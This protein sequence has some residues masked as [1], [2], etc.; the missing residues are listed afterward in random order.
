MY[1]SPSW[2]QELWVARETLWAGFLTSVQCSALAIVLGTLIGVVAGLALTYGRVW[3]RAPFR[4]YVDLI[5]GTPVF[6]LVLACFYM[7]P[8]LGWQ[9]GAFEAGV[10]GWGEPAQCDAVG[11]VPRVLAQQRA[12][13][14]LLEVLDH[15]VR[16]EAVLLQHSR[17]CH[18]GQ[19]RHPLARVQHG[20]RLVDELQGARVGLLGVVEDPR[21]RALLDHAA[22]AHDDDARPAAEGEVAAGAADVGGIAP[23]FPALRLAGRIQPGIAQR[24]A[25]AVVGRGV[26]L[27]RRGRIPPAAR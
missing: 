4:F 11:H 10:L 26:V 27:P 12:I 14:V 24:D 6:V 22:L 13:D 9:I 2:L 8:A 19:V 15:G 16:R 1:Q 21:G 18:P 20:R 7:A 17:R 3:T 5:R 25:D 23:R